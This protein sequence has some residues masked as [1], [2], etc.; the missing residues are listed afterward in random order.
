[1]RQVAYQAGCWAEADKINDSS[2][3]GLISSGV[4]LCL[5]PVECLL[6]L[7]RYT[8]K[9]PPPPSGCQWYDQLIQY[10]H[11]TIY[12]EGHRGTH[13]YYA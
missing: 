13:A 12:T 2:P 7:N 5:Y 11:D 10:G 8:E 4:S 1:M 6:M 9:T 3:S